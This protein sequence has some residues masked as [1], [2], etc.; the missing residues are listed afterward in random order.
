MGLRSFME[1]GGQWSQLG[2]WYG[3]HVGSTAWRTVEPAGGGT[4]TWAAF[5]FEL[6]GWS[7][8]LRA[9]Y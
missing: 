8:G 1:L 3:G 9:D 5:G 2:L 6:L 4:L 7:L